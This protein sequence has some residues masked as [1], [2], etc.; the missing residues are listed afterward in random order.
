M[1]IESA[2]LCLYFETQLRAGSAGAAGAID[3]PVQRERTTGWPVIHAADLVGALRRGV[4]RRA[5]EPTATRLFGATE[6]AGDEAAPA[7]G[8]LGV[9]DAR[10]LLF[11]VRSSVA[12][13]LWVTCPAALGRLRR[14]LG[15]TIGLPLPALAAPGAD[16]ILTSTGWKHGSDSLAAEDVVLAP[17]TGFD[18]SPL[19]ELLPS[20]T[21]GYDGFDREVDASLGVVADEVFGFLVRT[22]TEVMARGQE[23]ETA[24]LVEELLPADSLFY[25][26][27]VDLCADGPGGSP[28]EALAHGLDPY[29]RLGDDAAL[30]RGWARVAL[31]RAAGRAS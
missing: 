27:V 25:V 5:G 9:G 30:G 29:V 3:L 8:A 7:R 23:R 24:D 18:A 28:I 12:P 20:R 22:A 10:L 17:K 11:P 16:E 4:E 13:F 15:R 2:V 1:S 19:L 26:P 31:R 6:A 14:D 21:G